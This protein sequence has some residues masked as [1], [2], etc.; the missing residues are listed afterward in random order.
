MSELGA[1]KQTKKTSRGRFADKNVAKSKSLQTLETNIDD[2][3]SAKGEGNLTRVPSV[4]E[5]RVSKSLQKLNVP[6]WFK[7]SS[8]SRSGSTFSLYGSTQRRDSTSTM[9]SMGYPPSVSS[10]ACQSPLQQNPVV[11]RTRVTPPS[12]KFFRSPKLPMTPE[13][14]P[15]SPASISLPSDKFRNK[16]KPK[17]LMPIPI[18]PFS[19]LRLMFEKSTDKQ[20]GETSPVKPSTNSPLNAPSTTSPTSPTRPKHIPISETKVPPSILKKTTPLSVT[21]EERSPM[22]LTEHFSNGELNHEPYKQRKPPGADH[23][24]SSLQTSE[25][26]NVQKDTTTAQKDHTAGSNSYGVQPKNVSAKP[27]VASRPTPA[28]R[29]PK[30]AVTQSQNRKETTV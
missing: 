16:E 19:K 15:I 25:K 29:Q 20:S 18:V 7:N 28:P 22:Q 27:P 8:V 23:A 14:A 5:L 10:S 9:S 1:T 24:V 11:I 6:D 13:R 12:A 4:H 17:E 21:S 30:P 3:F 26:D 2:V